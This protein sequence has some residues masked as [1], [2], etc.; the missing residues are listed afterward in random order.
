LNVLISLVAH[1]R[2]TMTRWHH[3]RNYCRK[4]T[5]G[6]SAEVA[7]EKRGIQEGS[8]SSAGLVACP[9]PDMVRAKE[10]KPVF[11]VVCIVVC[12]DRT[13][14]VGGKGRRCGMRGYAAIGQEG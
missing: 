13:S 10:D 14:G 9:T 8:S 4:M 7:D 12:V 6:A 3:I 5:N 2:P 1:G 11:P